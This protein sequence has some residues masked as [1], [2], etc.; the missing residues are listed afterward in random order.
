LDESIAFVG[1]V[2]KRAHARLSSKLG[3]QTLSLF[4]EESLDGFDKAAP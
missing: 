3:Y 4:G 1:Q 2:C